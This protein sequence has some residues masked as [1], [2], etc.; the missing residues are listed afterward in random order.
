MIFQTKN[1]SK[2]PL[3]SNHQLYSELLNIS[4]RLVL[5][6]PN[7]WTNFIHKPGH[8]TYRY[9]THWYPP[10][11]QQIN[12]NHLITTFWW[13]QK[14]ESPVKHFS[15]TLK[16]TTGAKFPPPTQTDLTPP[17]KKNKRTLNKA[18]QKAPF[19]TSLQFLHHFRLFLQ[20]LR[21]YG[22]FAGG[23]IIRDKNYLHLQVRTTPWVSGVWVMS[24]EYMK[25]LFM[26]SKCLMIWSLKPWKKVDEY[27]FF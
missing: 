18:S 17:P 2:K 23:H 13:S 14:S 25:N 24:D 12:A 27:L 11:S 8:D 10:H 21:F 1:L 19:K 20:P 26:S 7:I 16:V 5:N 15:L 22:P 4:D 9:K 3:D 6:W